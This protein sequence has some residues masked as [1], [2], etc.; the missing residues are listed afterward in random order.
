MYHGYGF[1]PYG[2]YSPVP[3]NDQIYGTQHYHYSSPYF[4]PTSVPHT[5]N[6]A[7]PPMEVSTSA[8]PDQKPLSVDSVHAN[9]NLS[10]NGSLKVN[11]QG[12]TLKSTPYN[13]NSS[14]GKGS[15]PGVAAG[16][17]D[18]RFAY[19]GLHSP[20]PWSDGIELTD[21]QTENMAANVLNHS[22]SNAKNV[23]SSKSQNY[24]TSSHFMVLKQTFAN[25]F[26]V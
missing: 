13:S 2:P 23:L 15:L 18:S 21:G 4:Q 3:G 17:Q 6:L 1:A 7:N 19:D 12:T 26:T 5:P 14:F 9:A 10:N 16:Y 11:N 8:A 25:F 24:R 22:V 20:L